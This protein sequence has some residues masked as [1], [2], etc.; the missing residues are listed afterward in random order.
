VIAAVWARLQG[1][2]AFAGA[3]LAAIGAAYLAGRRDGRDAR[4]VEA[5]HEEQQTRRVGDAAARDAERTGAAERL[6]RGGF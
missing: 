6:R 2:L 5:V 3:A 1:W 4:S